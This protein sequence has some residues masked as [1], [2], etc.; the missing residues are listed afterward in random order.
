MKKLILLIIILIA[1]HRSFAY[2]L[3]ADS[4]LRQPAAQLPTNIDTLKRL[5]STT[6]NDTLKSVLYT[7]LATQYLNYDKLDSKTKR[8]FQAQ[9][10]YYTYEALHLYSRMSDTVGL[11]TSFDDLTKVYRAQ[12]NFVQAKWFAG[13][14]NSLSRGLK[15]MPN[16]M[17][18]LLVLAN[19]KMDIKDYTL[20]MH[21]LNEALKISKTN[22]SPKD[23]A[24]IQDN[25]VL[26]YNRLKNYNKADAAAK[27]RDFINDSLLKAEQQL[28]AKTQD[29]L[30]VKK[31]V[32]A[33]R[34]KSTKSSSARKMASL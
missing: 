20:A 26:L 22:H 1:G 30:Q 14:S 11:R 32:P 21:D 25:Y 23:E 33:V 28:V 29:S 6:N 8:N 9:A 18:S 19:I 15:D 10:L 24:K 4:A 34:K 7:Q 3:L 31:K 27:R 13:Q 2:T 17:A 5:I 12:R 16:I